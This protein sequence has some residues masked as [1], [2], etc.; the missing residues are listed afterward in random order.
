M[1][2]ESDLL[3]RLGIQ[4]RG[5]MAKEHCQAIANIRAMQTVIDDGVQQ[6]EVARSNGFACTRTGVSH[7]H[8]R[9]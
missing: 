4:A 1:I 7:E 3:V 2:Y 8:L 5:Q 9:M 6:L